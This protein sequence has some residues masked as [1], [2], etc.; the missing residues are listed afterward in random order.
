MDQGVWSMVNATKKL[1]L[2]RKVVSIHIHFHIYLYIYTN[3]CARTEH[4]KQGTMW[5]LDIYIH[6]C[7]IVIGDGGPQQFTIDSL[8]DGGGYMKTH[9]YVH[10]SIHICTCSNGWVLHRLPYPLH[11]KSLLQH[12][13]WVDIRM[14]IY[15]YSQIYIYIF[16]HIYIVIYKSWC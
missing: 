11:I 16:L 10:M 9:I 8:Q 2:L 3:F 12:K 15:V 7:E 13:C 5:M 4:K 14:Y 6:T 1:R